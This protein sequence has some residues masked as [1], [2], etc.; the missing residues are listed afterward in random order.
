MERRDFVRTG[1]AGAAV[2]LIG[3]QA[4]AAEQAA[5]H[6]GMP[7]IPAKS[8]A[9]KAVYTTAY[10]CLQT[11]TACVA[12]CNRVLATGDGA[13]AECQRAVMSMLPVCE[14]T[15]ANANMQL[16]DAA[17]LRQL[18]EVCANYNDYC[19]DAC[20]KHAEHHQ[21]CK[22]CMHSCRDCAKA[23]RAYLQA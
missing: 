9:L 20:E 12:V 2:G 13:M 21:E 22:D 14:A 17:L 4:G 5:H 7:V 3:V 19:A 10:A 11:A 15:A 1:L 18:V 8:D 16:V 23:C 6:A